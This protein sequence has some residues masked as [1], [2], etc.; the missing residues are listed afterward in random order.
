VKQLRFYPLSDAAHPPPQRHNDIAGRVFDGIVKFDESFY[1]SLAKMINEEPVQTR[2]LVAMGQLAAIGIEKGKDFKPDPATRAILS[3]AVAEAHACFTEM[4][5][6]H[7]VP[8]WTD[9]HWGTPPFLASAAKTGFSFQ[10]ANSLDVDGRG[11]LFFSACAVP[12]KLGAATLYL[13]AATDSNGAPLTG[14]HSYRL[15]VPPNV[16]A[17]QF[18]AVT[19]YDLESAAFISDSPKTE[20]NSFDDL[21]PDK[22]G[23]IEIYFGP[24]APPDKESN[25]IYTEPGKRWFTFFRFYGPEPAIRNKTWTLNDI[26]EMK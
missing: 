1:T 24:N 9:S 11:A 8:F 13:L 2:D 26:E 12:K 10:T 4:I 16:P 7:V 19:V 17:R 14:S 5:A 6:G 21:Q 3:N 25:W 15:R 18:W 23:A 22:N 20:V